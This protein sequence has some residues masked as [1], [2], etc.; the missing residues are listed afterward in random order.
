MRRFMA[1]SFFTCVTVL[2]VADESAAF[3]WRNRT[4]HC[5]PCPCYCAPCQLCPYV[6][7]PQCPDTSGGASCTCFG[8]L[9]C[10]KPQSECP[11]GKCYALKDGT[12]KCFCGCVKDAGSNDK[13]HVPSGATIS[14]CFPAMKLGILAEIL[15]FSDHSSL[16]GLDPNR[17]LP[18]K[19]CSTTIENIIMTCYP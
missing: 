12:G 15:C 17:D 16:S 1:V 8:T 14:F 7:L 5:C 3:G 13:Y 4:R 9:P 11:S 10:S 6:Q 19:A 2:C 18:A